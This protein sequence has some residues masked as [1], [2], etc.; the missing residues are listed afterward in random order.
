M[1]FVPAMPSMMCEHHSGHGD[2]VDGGGVLSKP[3]VDG[4]GGGD[5]GGGKRRP[6]CGDGGGLI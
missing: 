2:G 5:G 3:L 4:D 1:S 6:L